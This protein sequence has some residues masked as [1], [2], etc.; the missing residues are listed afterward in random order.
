MREV[1]IDTETTGV[2]VTAGH[3][4]VEIGC[5]EMIDRQITGAH[6][7]GY[8]N[9]ER[10]MP[11][12]AE[13]IHGLTDSFLAR[14]PSFA[15]VAHSFLAFVGEAQIVA[16]NAPFDLGFLN[17]ELERA[18]YNHFA[19][20][21]ITDT[22]ELARQKL[23]HVGHSLNQL[24]AHYG[25]S[26][27]EREKHG[28]LIDAELLARVYIELMI[29]NRQG[30]FDLAQHELVTVRHQTLVILQRPTP[31]PSPLT[32]EDRAAHRAFI[33]SAKINEPIW[34]DYFSVRDAEAITV[35][36]SAACNTVARTG[37][38]T[39]PTEAIKEAA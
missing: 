22:L 39:P 4:V 12:D 32:G 15:S 14:Q 34:G 8:F 23:P 36:L 24:C 20:E 9:P 25:I 16:H 33:F 26:T 19:P 5:V 18:G 38:A 1:V 7:H 10:R 29:G 17:A 35:E 6:W 11:K 30:S 3:R 27:K 21:R 28:A 31:L 2:E 13:V 37:G